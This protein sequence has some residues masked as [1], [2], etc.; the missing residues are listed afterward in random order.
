MATTMKLH[1]GTPT[2]HVDGKPLFA[3]YLWGQS[4]TVDGYPSAAATEHYAAAGI[5]LHALDLGVGREWCGPGQGR[6]GHFDFSTVEQRFGYILEA[7]PEA[8][9][10][11][12]IQ[13]EM[14]PH[15]AW[16]RR[17]RRPESSSSSTS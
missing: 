16:W 3:A 8:R 15:Q 9:L 7:D 4:P 2:P 5:H 6:A 17:T 14:S 10:H 1:N 12:R 13:L 11:L